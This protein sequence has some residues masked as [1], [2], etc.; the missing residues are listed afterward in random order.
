MRAQAFPDCCGIHVISGFG[1]T[2]TA[3]YTTQF[4]TIK[5]IEEWIEKT[6]KGSGQGISLAAL[7]QDQKKHYG[8]MMERLGFKEL[9]T[10]CYHPGHGNVITLY[11]KA[12]QEEKAK[13]DAK[14]RK[15]ENS[16][17][18]RTQNAEAW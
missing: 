3:S 11:G 1:K 12:V 13:P 17:F 15:T 8:K 7:N 5:E 16:V 2:N 6:A 18:Q 10:D 14:P 9:L 4:T